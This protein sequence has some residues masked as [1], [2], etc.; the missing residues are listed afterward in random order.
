M[1]IHFLCVISVCVLTFLH[2]SIWLKGGIWSIPYSST[3]AGRIIS[4]LRAPGGSYH[5][6]DEEGGSCKVS[7]LL[8][9]NKLQAEAEKNHKH[10]N[11]VFITSFYESLSSFNHI[12]M[13]LVTAWKDR[14]YWQPLFNNLFSWDSS[15][16]M[17]N[18]ILKKEAMLLKIK[19]QSINYEL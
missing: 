7:Q 17:E 8:K 18:T 5:R 6:P 19:K 3:T 4:V 9:S 15:R 16:I 1:S 13:L 14:H 12:K 11:Q 10:Q 2:V